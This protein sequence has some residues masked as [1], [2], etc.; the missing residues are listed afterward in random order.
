MI[1][2]RTRRSNILL[3]K[4]RTENILNFRVEHNYLMKGLRMVEF[5]IFG[6]EVINGRKSGSR[7]LLKKRVMV[8]KGSKVVKSSL[9]K[10]VSM[11]Q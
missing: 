3:A 9:G 7:K 11:K 10:E 8:E 2:S 5:G 6:P 1:G 4:R